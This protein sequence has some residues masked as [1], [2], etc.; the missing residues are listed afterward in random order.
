MKS[1]TMAKDYNLEI[2]LTCPRIFS[3]IHDLDLRKFIQ[4]MDTRAVHSHT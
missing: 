1:L 3:K 4:G 2:K